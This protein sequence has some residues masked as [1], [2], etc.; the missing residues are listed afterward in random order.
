MKKYS[1]VKK[2]AAL[3]VA[4]AVTLSAGNVALAG[5][6]T[7]SFTVNNGNYVEV[8][9]GNRIVKSGASGTDAKFTCGIR[10]SDQDTLSFYVINK[11]NHIVSSSAATFRNTAAKT[12]KKAP[13]REG[14]GLKGNPFYFRCSLSDRSASGKLDVDYKFEP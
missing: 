10:I 8:L 12:T 1:L 6:K 13:Y 11:N 7:G 4:A 14:K 3:A 2:G 9:K 5:S